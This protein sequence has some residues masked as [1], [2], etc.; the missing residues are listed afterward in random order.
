MFDHSTHRPTICV[1]YEYYRTRGGLA[2]DSTTATAACL[3]GMKSTNIVSLRPTLQEGIPTTPLISSYQPLDVVEPLG[4]FLASPTLS[5]FSLSLGSI[6]GHILLLFR[7]TY[8]LGDINTTINIS[9]PW[10]L[11]QTSRCLWALQQFAR[12]QD[13]QSDRFRTRLTA[14]SRC[15]K[16]KQKKTDVIHRRVDSN[17]VL[18]NPP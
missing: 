10:L 11:R 17:R 1:S 16:W 6:L 7:Y 15:P 4:L 8:C 12:R 9:Q 14:Q 18:S 2:F 3:L 13:L 5:P